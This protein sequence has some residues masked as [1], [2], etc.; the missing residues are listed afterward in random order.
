[1]G[2]SKGVVEDPRIVVVGRIALLP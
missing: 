1:M 2:E